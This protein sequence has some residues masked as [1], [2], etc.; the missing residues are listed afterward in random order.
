MAFVFNFDCNAQERRDRLKRE[1][2][3]KKRQ[4]REAMEAELEV[5]YGCTFLLYVCVLV[6]VQPLML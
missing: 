5:I 2:E 1:W 6:V 4:E 3:E